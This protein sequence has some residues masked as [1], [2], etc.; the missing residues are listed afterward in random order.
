MADSISSNL[1][2]LQK[3]IIT[4]V[5]IKKINCRQ[6]SVNLPSEDALGPGGGHINNT[7]LRTFRCSLMGTTA[8]YPGCSQKMRRGELCAFKRRSKSRSELLIKCAE[9]KLNVSFYSGVAENDI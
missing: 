8:G 6:K 9:R 1:A 7:D 4:F 3:K 5:I 2:R